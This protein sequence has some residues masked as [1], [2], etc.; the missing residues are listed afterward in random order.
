[1][2]LLEVFDNECLLY[3]YFTKILPG[4]WT[5]FFTSKCILKTSFNLRQIDSVR[6]E[7]FSKLTPFGRMNYRHTQSSKA[8]IIFLSYIQHIIMHWLESPV[9]FISG[10]SL[11]KNKI[12]I[13][14]FSKV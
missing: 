13:Q 4:G 10:K 1:M 6:T 8:K 5:L 14:Y 11:Q 9:Y 2:K 12:P 7:L 3:F